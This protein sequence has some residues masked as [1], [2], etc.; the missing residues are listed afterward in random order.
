MDETQGLSKWVLYNATM[1]DFL[2]CQ[3]PIIQNSVLNLKSNNFGFAEFPNGCGIRPGKI[4]LYFIPTWPDLIIGVAGSS[5]ATWASS[6]PLLGWLAPR[7][8]EELLLHSSPRHLPREALGGLETR[9]LLFYPQVREEKEKNKKEVMSERKCLYS[10]RFT[11][12]V[13]RRAGV[14]CQ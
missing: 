5:H 3:G 2:K 13:W 10:F 4:H 9:V 8:A 11:Q 6:W 1:F 14:H 12:A 7:P